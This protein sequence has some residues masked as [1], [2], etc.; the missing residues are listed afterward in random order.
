LLALPTIFSK[1]QPAS[2]ENS[3]AAAG[4]AFPNSN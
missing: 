4:G 2:E 1:K 3:R